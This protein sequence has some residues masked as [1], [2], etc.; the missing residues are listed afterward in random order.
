M[1]REEII[2]NYLTC[3]H[4]NAE[5]SVKN[6]WNFWFWTNEHLRFEWCGVYYGCWKKIKKYLRRQL[7]R[8]ENI[9]NIKTCVYFIEIF[10][11][12]WDFVLTKI[13]SFIW[14]V[15]P[16]KEWGVMW[17]EISCIKTLVKEIS[18]RMSHDACRKN[19]LNAPPGGVRQL[20]KGGERSL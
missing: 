3:A 18:D 14:C 1:P 5:Q 6:F 12:N 7:V 10:S 20:W 8:R 13:Y 15:P 9:R 11:M 19:F 16:R 17:K 2:G 4:S